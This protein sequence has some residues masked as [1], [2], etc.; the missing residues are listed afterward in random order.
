M[1]LFCEF[2]LSF[3]GRDVEFG[4]YLLL[5]PCFQSK[6]AMWGNS[7]GGG[8]TANPHT[9][10]SRHGVRQQGVREKVLN[11]P[12]NSIHYLIELP[13]SVWHFMDR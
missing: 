8:I 3:E 7:R 13:H 6:E 9:L 4:G 5:S 12:S 2:L 10:S 11:V 1:Y